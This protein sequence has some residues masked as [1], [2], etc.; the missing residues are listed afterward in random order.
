MKIEFSGGAEEV[1]GSAIIVETNY[2]KVALDYGIKI[3]EGL[4]YDLPRD[5]DAVI[6]THAHLDHSGNLLTLSD[7]GVSTIGSE[8][9]RDV[10]SELLYDLL[11]IHRMNGD[12]L[13][14]DMSS[15]G[16]I[17]DAWISQEKVGLPGMEVHLYPAGHVLGA[18]MVHL[19]ADNKQ[20]LYTGDFCLHE[21]EI[22]EGTDVSLLPKEPDVLIMETTYGGTLRPSRNELLKSFFESIVQTEEKGGNILI[23]TFAFHRMQ[24]MAHR[25]DSAMEAGHLPRYNAYYLSGLGHKIN[26]Y[27]HKYQN[28]LSKMIQD[29]ELAFDYRFVKHLKRADQIHEPAIV[30]CT[31]G[32]GHA[33]VSRRLSL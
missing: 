9:T 10:V 20:I 30:V 3:E 15:I 27:F 16:R 31:A 24:E 19:K 29:E 26:G 6:V 5:L 25:I 17:T 13:P 23:P 7:A 2:T 22:L 21:T 8:A 32:F 14:Y 18:R 28:H 12:T 33:G 11:K 1:G 4:R